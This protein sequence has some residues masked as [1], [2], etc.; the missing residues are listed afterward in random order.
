MGFYVTIESG[1]IDGSVPQWV[2]NTNV[3]AE[4]PTDYTLSVIIGSGN[5]ASPPSSGFCA[6]SSIEGVNVWS[7]ISNSAVWSWINPEWKDS[8]AQCRFN[9]LQKFCGTF[10]DESIH[11]EYA[12]C[13]DR[14]VSAVGN[15]TAGATCYN[16][17]P[18]PPPPPTIDE[19]NFDDPSSELPPSIDAP[20]FS[21]IFAYFTS[22]GDLLKDAQV[23]REVI[24]SSS[25]VLLPFFSVLLAFVVG[26]F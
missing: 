24:A 10:F 15:N 11:E 7:S 21:T 13:S 4:K 14:Y 23:E 18:P 12:C 19:P 20:V 26:L 5:C 6:D 17:P 2:R 22:F 9:E 16:I 3:D 25:S 1:S 8:E